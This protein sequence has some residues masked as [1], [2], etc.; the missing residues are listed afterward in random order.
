MIKR[1]DI[2]ILIFLFLLLFGLESFVTYR[3]L[4]SQTPGANDYYSRWHGARAL[5]VEG[6]NPYGL[7]VTEEIQP[8]IKIDPSEV[9]RGGF[10]YPLHVIFIFWPLAYLSYP[11]AQAIWM[12]MLQWFTIGMAVALLGWQRWKPGVSELIIVIL[13][14]LTFYITVRSIFLGQFTL[15]VT[16]FLAACLWA[17]QKE[18]D[19]LAGMLLAATSIKPQMVLFVGIWFVIWAIGQRRWRFLG[20]LFGGGAAMLVGSMAL[21]P[22]WPLAFYEDIGR[23]Q[24]FAGGRNP[25]AMLLE[26]VWK[27]YPGWVFTAVSTLLILGM[28]WTWWQG[29][30]GE[31]TLFNRA[32]FWSIIV[33]IFI[34]FQ[35]GTTN[36]TLL[37]IPMFAWTMQA[38]KRWGKWPAFA[39]F[40][41]LSVGV[42]TLFFN[43]ISGDYENPVLFLPLPLLSL[44]VLLGQ[45]VVRWRSGRETAVSSS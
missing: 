25:L 44:A 8:I 33:G 14:V 31:E 26:M 6:R 37:L 35:T 29:R 19:V 7:D 2:F 9:G 27:G 36:Q 10:N 12:V 45:E 18:R 32:L 24:R 22:P 4:T 28:L 43:T 20:G 17:L 23:Y 5:L 38:V 34:T 15:P 40:L 41:L 42:W 39:G 3:V 21:Y 13:A 1:R 16:F 11:W 30:R